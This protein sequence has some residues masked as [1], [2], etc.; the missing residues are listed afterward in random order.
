MGP[1][2]PLEAPV[3]VSGVVLAPVPQNYSFQTIQECSQIH[4][5]ALFGWPRATPAPCLGQHVAQRTKLGW[6]HVRQVIALSPILSLQPFSCIFSDV[7]TAAPTTQLG[8][9][10]N[11]TPKAR[12]SLPLSAQG[13]TKAQA[14]KIV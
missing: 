9:V 14:Q 4:H 2:L 11:K 3:A 1:F 6:P 8:P 12:V 5:L 10:T 13:D 7:R